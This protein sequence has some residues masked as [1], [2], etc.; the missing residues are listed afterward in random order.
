M[1][2]EKN[3]LF[4]NMYTSRF[5]IAPRSELNNGTLSPQS[6]K[7]FMWSPISWDSANI[8]QYDIIPMG[9][10]TGNKIRLKKRVVIGSWPTFVWQHWEQN[11]G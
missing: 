2:F 9:L 6:T 4:C 3:V 10:G 1:F 7:D 5:C 11:R 8:T